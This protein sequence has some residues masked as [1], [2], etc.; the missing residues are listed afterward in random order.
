MGENQGKNLN[1][2]LLIEEDVWEKVIRGHAGEKSIAGRMASCAHLML[3]ARRKNQQNKGLSPL[4]K[5]RQRLLAAVF[6]SGEVETQR[7]PSGR[8]AYLPIDKRL[9]V[10]LYLGLSKICAGLFNLKND[11]FMHY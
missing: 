11:F 4:F 8:H 3:K 1:N 7:L 10:F 6:L 9:P 2:I 5:K